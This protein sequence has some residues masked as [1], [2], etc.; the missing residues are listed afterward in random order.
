RGRYGDSTM[1]RLLVVVVLASLSGC[2]S[3]LLESKLPISVVYVMAAAPAENAAANQSTL[4]LAIA[5]PTA[6]PGLDTERIA[7]LH[8]ARRL[9]YYREA[10]WGAALPQ[11]VQSLLV[12]SLQNQKLFRSVTTEQ[13]RVTASYLLDLDIRDFQAEYANDSS[14][15]T[16]RVTLVASLIRI[17]D[18]KLIGMYPVTFTVL[19]SANRMSAVAAAF[20]SAA[21]Q[22]ATSLGKQ[23][24][25]TIAKN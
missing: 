11:V 8:E 19:A 23:A 1:M 10:Q 24:A 15:P 7:I 21:R 12:G 13:A 9:D 6:A 14:A 2:T 16:V 25:D 4:D 17:S 3:S 5:L 18:R 20:E 22:A